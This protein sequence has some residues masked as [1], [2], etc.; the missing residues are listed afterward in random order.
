M[1]G[2]LLAHVGTVDTARDMD[3][4]RRAVGDA[5]L[6]YLG[7]S[8]GTIYGTTYAHYFPGTVRALALDGAVDPR[9]GPLEESRTQTKGFE[10]N[11]SAFLAHCQAEGSRCGWHVD[12]PRTAYQDLIGQV[13][14]KPLPTHDVARPLTLNLFVN[15]VV[16]AMYDTQ[17]WPPLEQALARASDGDGTAMLALAD[18]LYGRDSHGQYPNELDAFTAISCIDQQFPRDLSTYVELFHEL[19]AA[20]PLVTASEANPVGPGYTCGLWPVHPGGSTL[21]TSV[22]GVPPILIVGSSDDPA[23]PFSEA[24]G[25]QQVI[26]GSYLLERT[27]EGHTGYGASTCVQQKVDAYLIDPTALPSSKHD[28]CGSD[29]SGATTTT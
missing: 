29:G 13:R 18:G 8:Y 19:N 24:L 12:D 20:D 1:S 15:A 27:G 26:E 28:I 14:A 16:F 3:A 25:L 9:T 17:L 4:I 6:T 23:T 7:F 11:V 10:S 2:N 21:P 22:T 5:K